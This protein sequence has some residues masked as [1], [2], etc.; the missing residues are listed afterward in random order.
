[1]GWAYCGKDNN[2]REIGY[3]IEATCDHPGCNEQI[4]R[5]MGYACG[6]MHGKEE[7]YCDKYFCSKHLFYIDFVDIPYSI[8]KE[9][10]ELY[11]KENYNYEDNL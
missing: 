11:I 3:G 6:G 1:M 7:Y 5:G 2:G 4:D 10:S 8:C 9:C